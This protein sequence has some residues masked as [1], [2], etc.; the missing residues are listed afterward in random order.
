M[1]A[2]G[3]KQTYAPQKAMSA[4]PPIAT[5][6]AD[7]RTQGHVRSTLESGHVHCDR[8]CLL[9]ANSGHSRVR[10]SP[11]EKP[12]HLAAAIIHDRRSDEAL[13]TVRTTLAMQTT[14]ISIVM[15]I[16]ACPL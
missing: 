15:L 13:I 14:T 10:L 4:L 5:A 7:F 1:S 16:I 2:L 3:Q 8:P 11:K 6:K 12:W 9:W